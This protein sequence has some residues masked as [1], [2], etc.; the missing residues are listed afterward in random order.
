MDIVKGL[1]EI[2][3]ALMFVQIELAALCIIIVA[4]TRKKS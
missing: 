4:V 3:V 2:A 1:H